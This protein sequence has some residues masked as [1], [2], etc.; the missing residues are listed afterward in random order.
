MSLLA[1]QWDYFFNAEHLGSSWVNF[2]LD[3][4]IYGAFGGAASRSTDEQLGAVCAGTSTLV[5]A[6]AGWATIVGEMSI[7]V[8]TYCVDYQ[9]C[10]GVGMAQ[11]LDNSTEHAAFEKSYWSEQKLSYEQA[12]GW[13]TSLSSPS[14]S[15]LSI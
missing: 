14:P 6:Q 8:R 7:G 5:Q 10:F 2:G 13:S 3:T 11:Q 15:G 9:D 12:A 4:H 1:C